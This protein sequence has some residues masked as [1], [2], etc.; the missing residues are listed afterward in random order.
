MCP[1]HVGQP[2]PFSP[3]RGKHSF[4]LA[5]DHHLLAVCAPSIILGN[6]LWARIDQYLDSR[7]LLRAPGATLAQS[8][9]IVTLAEF[10][11]RGLTERLF[12]LGQSTEIERS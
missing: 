11:A 9:A 8:R 7:L 3:N 2:I 1:S 6:I 10:S 12:L 4:P 5:L